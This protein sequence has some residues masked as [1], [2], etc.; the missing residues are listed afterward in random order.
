MYRDGCSV[1]FY[2]NE[3]VVNKATAFESHFMLFG[4]FNVILR[5]YYSKYEA[6][7]CIHLQLEDGFV[8]LIPCS[9]M[10]RNHKD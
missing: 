6:Y 1:I 4:T 5:G 8:R 3:E 10:Q 2:M 9:A 7:E